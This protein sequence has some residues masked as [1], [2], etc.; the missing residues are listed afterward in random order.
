[1]VKTQPSQSYDSDDSLNLNRTRDLKDEARKK[2]IRKQT[3]H[4]AV[5]PKPKTVE[6]DPERE[7]TWDLPAE[8]SWRTGK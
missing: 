1:M 3:R 2:R 7:K 8:K 4:R 6:I 5:N